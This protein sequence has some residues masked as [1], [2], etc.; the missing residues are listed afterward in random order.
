M[1]TGGAVHNAGHMGSA[2]MMNKAVSEKQ[3]GT[4]RKQHTS[5]ELMT[6]SAELQR[7]RDG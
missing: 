5:T 1:S 6:A 3:R 7:E 4:R 2:A